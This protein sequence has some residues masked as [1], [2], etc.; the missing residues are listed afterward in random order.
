MTNLCRLTWLHDQYAAL[1]R[2]RLPHRQSRAPSS[3]NAPLRRRCH[4]TQLRCAAPC[5]VLCVP[6]PR[7]CATS[8][9]GSPPSPANASFRRPR[10]APSRKM[11]CAGALRQALALPC[12]PRPRCQ[13]CNPI[14]TPSPWSQTLNEPC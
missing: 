6:W 4:G 2:S 12:R 8:P 9:P 3:T 7:G 11:S 14:G 13:C 10:D 1:Y 5:G